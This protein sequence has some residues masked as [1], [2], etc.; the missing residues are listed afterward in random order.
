MDTHYLIS[1]GQIIARGVRLDLTPLETENRHV[2][3]APDW[4]LGITW[5]QDPECKRLD[6]LQ[7]AEMRRFF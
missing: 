5:L 1:D 3:F 7:A 4:D 2:V 6:E